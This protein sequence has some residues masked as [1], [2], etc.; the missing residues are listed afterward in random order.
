M[1]PSP[2]NFP[3][4]RSGAERFFL[5]AAILGVSL[6]LIRLAIDPDLVT[7]GILSMASISALIFLRGPGDLVI[8]SE[9]IR[10]RNLA[11]A[12]SQLRQWRWQNVR[13]ARE[14]LLI[15]HRGRHKLRL[16]TADAATIQQF[17]TEHATADNSSSHEVAITSS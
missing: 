6:G 15:T 8:A 10:F 16:G 1:D 4:L 14:L 3:I 17:L 2:Q 12:W 11:I 7:L 13:G 9:G 5:S